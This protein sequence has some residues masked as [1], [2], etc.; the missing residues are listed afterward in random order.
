MGSPTCTQGEWH[1]APAIPRLTRVCPAGAQA[2]S[3]GSGPTEMTATPRTVVLVADDEGR[4]SSLVR[5]LG[6][7][8]FRVESY[9]SA[10]DALA[11]GA[12]AR[13]AC[14]VCDVYLPRE[15]GFGLCRK[16]SQGG[17]RPP[18]IFIT[19]HDLPAVRAEAEALGAANYLIKPFAGRE[20]VAAVRASLASA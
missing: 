8:G 15:T 16:L 7:A 11:A 14:I 19:A 12:A 10:E 1:P 13:A 3:G 17:P 18:V 20:L 5:I 6:L 2:E 4:R 9:S